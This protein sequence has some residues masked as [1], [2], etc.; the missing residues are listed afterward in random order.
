MKSDNNEDRGNQ[1]FIQPCGGVI[2]SVFDRHPQSRDLVEPQVTNPSAFDS[3]LIISRMH[4]LI[5]Q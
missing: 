3:L 5:N 4:W 2:P 1:Q